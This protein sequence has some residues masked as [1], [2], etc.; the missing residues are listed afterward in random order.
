MRAPAPDGVAG[1]EYH[2]DKPRWDSAEW[3]IVPALFWD[4][5]RA[6]LPTPNR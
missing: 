4:A 1:K 2:D 6:P 3:G 5:Q